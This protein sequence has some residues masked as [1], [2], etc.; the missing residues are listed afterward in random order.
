MRATP[1]TAP[2]EPMRSCIVT[3]WDAFRALDL[4]RLHD[5]M[6]QPIV[7]DLRNIYRPEDMRRRGF[8][9]VSVGRP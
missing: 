8:T 4:R 7:V 2:R 3:E 9:Y 6:A 1:M 5:L